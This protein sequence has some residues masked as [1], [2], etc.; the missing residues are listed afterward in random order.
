MATINLFP[1]DTVQVDTLVDANGG[2][3]GGIAK[4]TYTEMVALLDAANN[5]GSGSSEYLAL[6]GTYME[7]TSG[8]PNT[9][10]GKSAVIIADNTFGSLNASGFSGNS[11]TFV[12]LY[13]DNNNS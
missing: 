4:K 2:A 5:A 13:P 11:G 8:V 9:P 12:T 3:V 1:N 7:I 6:D 10:N